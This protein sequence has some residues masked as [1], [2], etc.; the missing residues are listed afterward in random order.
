M[1]SEGKRAKDIISQTSPAEQIA[2]QRATAL[3]KPGVAQALSAYGQGTTDLQSALQQA[4]GA[5][6]ATP[7]VDPL[8]AAT[9]QA[10]LG[11]DTSRRFAGE[12]ITQGGPGK[13]LYGEGGLMGQLGTEAQQ[14][15]TEGW[16]MQ[17]EDVTAY[18]QAAGQA[19]RMAGEQEK[20]LASQLAARGL[21]SGGSGA[22][23][24]GFSGIQGNKF[25]QLANA[26]RQIADQRMARNMQMLQ[27]NRQLQSQLGQ[28]YE[29][30]LSGQFGREMSG[31]Q[32]GRGQEQ[33][34]AQNEFQR[35]Q[36]QQQQENVGFE[37]QEATRT[38]GLGE[39]L[40]G[41]A[42]QALGGLAGG[43]GAGLGGLATGGLGLLGG[44]MGI[45]SAKG[46]IGGVR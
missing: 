40:G 10:A 13:Q 11:A 17:P 33:Q 28:E 15:G 4:K 24:Q 21:A 39:V 45:P 19:A 3:Q 44:K 43:L 36:A 7:G 25:E 18:G 6:G 9:E 23:A 31:T 42:T 16:K 20:G 32:F 1:G 38:P 46:G 27:Q 34:A 5:M 22:A 26:Q 14:L 30:A 12:Q 8:Q 41:A 35:R 29:G 37:Q 2:S